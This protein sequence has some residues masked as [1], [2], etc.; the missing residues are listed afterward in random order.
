MLRLCSLF[1]Y[2]LFQLR[3]I[4]RQ[5]GHYAIGFVT[6]LGT[7]LGTRLGTQLILIFLILFS[8]ISLAR[9]VDVC[10]TKKIN[11]ITGLQN[12]ACLI[13]CQTYFDQNPEASP[14]KA[15]EGSICQ[16]PLGQL[17]QKFNPIENAKNTAA[18]FKG[19]FQS[20]VG[21]PERMAA[22]VNMGDQAFK[23]ISNDHSELLKLQKECNKSVACK[24]EIARKLP[25][26]SEKNTQGDYLIS[27]INLEKSL[28][29]VDSW[30][31]INQA[32]TEKRKLANKCLSVFS[33]ASNQAAQRAA[34]KK[35]TP[36]ESQ[37]RYDTIKNENPQCLAALD[38]QP[39]KPSDTK[40]DE[41]NNSWL[42]S[43]G[44]KLQCYPPEKL[45][46]LACYEVTSLVVD[47]LMLL[48]PGGLG[49]KALK[50]AG[51][52]YI[53]SEA[54]T[55]VR[56]P[57]RLLNRQNLIK[58]YAERTFVSEAENT[59]WIN[60]A[61]ARP[62][63]KNTLFVD[64]ENSQLKHLNDTLK[65]KNL[66][67]SLTNL[68]KDY[69]LKELEALKIKYPNINFTLY[70]DFK[71]IRVAIENQKSKDFQ[72]ELDWALSQANSKFKKEVIEKDILRDEDLTGHWFRSGIGQTADEA[73][74]AARYAR[75]LKDNPMTNFNAPEVR[76]ALDTTYSDVITS[77]QKLS[78]DFS[79][80]ELFEPVNNGSS[81]LPKR[82][83]FEILRKEKSPEDIQNVIEK[84]FN[85]KITLQQAQDLKTYATQVDSFS[86]GIYSAKRI[87]ATLDNANKGG[88]SM[89]FAGM[90]AY[91]IRETALGLTRSKNL[92]D[93]LEQARKAEQT[94][95]K[96][97]KRRMEDKIILIDNYLGKKKGHGSIDMKCSGDDCVAV[98]PS[99][100]S[101][102]EQKELISRLSKTDAPSGLR[103]SFISPKITNAES[104]NMIATHGESLEKLTRKY[105]QG[106]IP[107]TTLSKITLGVSME[108]AEI[109]QGAARLLIGN[110]QAKLGKAEHG[111]IKKAFEKALTNLN[112]EMK[113][114]NKKITTGYQMAK[115]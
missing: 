77:Q 89:D 40:S 44:I 103:V 45:N 80:S 14:S 70:S 25:K 69:V 102:K 98:L 112:T 82:E 39:P 86:S 114:K 52:K 56:N 62:P 90:G 101:Q 3:L 64:I 12:Q 100:I 74:M 109:G 67:T 61:L 88:I 71:S 30:T 17:R 97:F 1:F 58:L 94:V 9:P 23:A 6:Q 48:G 20:V 96:V 38:L 59:R 22:L 10:L 51:R 42:E 81:Y 31:L 27:D 83:V 53:P 2:F 7:Q 115:P 104:R 16:T 33:N 111:Q 8:E 21:L 78:N 75:S 106:Q 95:T 76:Q 60:V 73:N 36:A 24:I 63:P 26:Y 65:D 55:V 57:S 43:L 113:A 108:G 47:P 46:E 85:Q 29:Q 93:A 28:S 105:L 37:Y 87:N 92:D 68:H 110:S 32:R 11:S 4:T 18:C 72:K 79:K 19:A 107:Q 15:Q 5:S 13:E 66:V 41:N 99:S 34:S 54:L 50:V 91:N 84:T 49:A 35:W